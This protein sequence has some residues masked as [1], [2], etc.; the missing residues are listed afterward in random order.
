MPDAPTTVELQPAE[1]ETLP[2]RPWPAEQR[3]DAACP[4]VSSYR[5]ENSKRRARLL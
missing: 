1:R 2:S 4:P 5:G 3:C